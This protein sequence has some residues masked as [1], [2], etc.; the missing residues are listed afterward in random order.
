MIK[1]KG[2]I[3]SILQLAI[4]L[5]SWVTNWYTEL[6]FA[7]TIVTV[8]MVLDKLGKGIVLR[9]LMALHGCVVCLLMPLLGYLVY[10]HNNR[11]S[12][13]WVRYMP[14]SDDMYFGLALPAMAG[15][16][17]TVCWPMN[18]LPATDNGTNLQDMLKKAK[19]ILE[20][21]PTVG[22]ILL[23]IGLGVFSV[24]DLLPQSLQ[25][26]FLLFFFS[27]FAGLLYLYFTPRVAYRVPILVLFGGFIVFHALRTGMFT[28]IAYM[29]ITLFSFFFIGRKSPMWK[30]LIG[31][32]VSIFLLIVIQSVKQNYRK[33]TWTRNYEGSRALLFGNLVQ[34]R[35]QSTSALS[36]ADAFFPI[37][38]RTN[39]GYNV[40]MVMKRIPSLQPYDNG[41][42]L[43]KTF[44]SALVPRVLW[45]DKPEAGG[46]FNM[47]YYTGYVI[48][49]WST[50]VGPLGEAYGSFGVIGG[51]IYMTLMGAF[52][53]WS[54]RKVFII[55]NRIPLLLFWIPV[56]FYQV[57]Y[58]LE[59]DTLQI[60]NSLFKAAFFTW[61]LTKFVPY[62]FG[63]TKKQVYKKPP[64]PLYQ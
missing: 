7:L 49:G 26:A 40:A 15:F 11:L 43:A 44:A 39:Q 25:F 22:L 2:Y 34:Q 41:A 55:A 16:I 23:I 33:A 54:Y 21:R 63:I 36:T 56:L 46:K 27:A 47:K 59:S 32:T 3:F 48:E 31:F 35:L 17:F 4:F 45:P 14:V 37:Y 6:V 12:S 52:V 57:T 19:A 42:N 64:L 60:L 18:S 51:I 29:G 62:W 1:F 58:A 13:L 50:N 38:Y 61:I 9:E 20:K 28:I 5:L 10:D 24:S 8:I 30:K 53:R